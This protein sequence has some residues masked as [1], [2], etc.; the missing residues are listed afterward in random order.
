MEKT[1]NLEKALLA[2]RL[3]SKKE[4]ERAYRSFQRFPFI[5]LQDICE[6]ISGE[7]P[8]FYYT[9]KRILKQHTLKSEIELSIFEQETFS[10]FGSHYQYAPKSRLELKA[11]VCSY[12]HAPAIQFKNSCAATLIEAIE[13]REKG[14]QLKHVPLLIAAAYLTY[15]IAELT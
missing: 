10:K 5:L 12:F 4:I 8:S 13:N 6:E 1:S 2:S 3:L 9:A 7:K 11:L 14:L 15:K